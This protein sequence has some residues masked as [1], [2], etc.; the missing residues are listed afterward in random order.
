MLKLRKQGL[1]RAKEA[2]KELGMKED[3]TRV[4]QWEIVIA[5]TSCEIEVNYGQ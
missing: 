3:L 4:R 5:D 1:L 2:I